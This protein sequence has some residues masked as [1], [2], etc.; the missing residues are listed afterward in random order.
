MTSGKPFSE[1][2]RGPGRTPGA[3]AAELG[4][5]ESWAMA[6]REGCSQKAASSLEGK[7]ELPTA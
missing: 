5:P 4:A 1:M 6:C 3:I 7:S 2:L